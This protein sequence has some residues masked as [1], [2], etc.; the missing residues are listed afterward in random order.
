MRLAISLLVLMLVG[1]LGTFAQSNSP[2]LGQ[3]DP[4][5]TGPP[6]QISGCLQRTSDS[7]RFIADSGNPHLLIGDEKTVN[8]HEGDRATLQ[9]YRDYNRDASASGD[10]GMSHGMRSFQVENIAADKGKCNVR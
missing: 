3:G 5:A 4:G 10:E 7:Y 2:Y 6:L 8:S 1:A 9:G